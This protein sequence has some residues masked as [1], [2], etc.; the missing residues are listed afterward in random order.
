MGRN[1]SNKPYDPF[2]HVTAR[3]IGEQF[4]Q[5]TVALK[6]GADQSVRTEGFNYRKDPT[7]RL[8]YRRTYKPCRN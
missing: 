6:P 1:K 7:H 4:Q 3:D 8:N 5:T 2:A